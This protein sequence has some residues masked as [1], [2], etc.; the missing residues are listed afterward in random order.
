MCGIVG[1]IDKTKIVGNKSDVIT[2]MSESIRHRGGDASGVFTNDNVAIAH[3]RLAILDLSDLAN[4]PMQNKHSVLAY[5]GEIYNHSEIRD[6][7]LGDVEIT[8]YSDTATLFG[9]LNKYSLDGVLQDI[10]GMYSFS[11]YDQN[12]E[13]V[14]LCVDKFGIKPLY[15]VDTPDWFAWSSEAKAFKELPGFKLELNESRIGEYMQFRY[16]LGKETLYKNVFRVMPGECVNYKIKGGLVS[17]KS[18]FSLLKTGSHDEDLDTLV[19]IGV[20]K[21]LMGD[22]KVGVQL[23]GGIDSSL[24]GLIAQEESV[25][26]I[27]TFSIGLK[28]D[29]WNEFKYSDYVA[30]K[31][32]SKH[33]KIIFTPADF[34]DNLRSVIYHLDEPLVHPNTVPM[35]LLAK[36]ARN[37]VKVLLTGEGADEVFCGYGRYES[38]SEDTN[39]DRLISILNT[40][41]LTTLLKNTP[42]TSCERSEIGKTLRGNIVSRMSTLDIRS[43]LPH[44]LMRQDKAGMMAN[45]ENRVPFLYEPIVQHG[46]NLDSNEKVGERGT[47]TPLK[48]IA[49]KYFPKDFVLREKCGFGLPISTWLKDKKIMKPF[50]NSLLE[51]K[52]MC[53]YFNMDEVNRLINEHLANGKDNSAILFALI[54]LDI[55]NDIFINGNKPKN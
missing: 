44:V 15:Y 27:H 36:E 7:K 42:I 13:E 18:N 53:T 8:S 21:H 12:K 41:E 37:D 1:F 51:S 30:D 2:R 28:D 14:N 47:K 49:L 16:A 23:S 40:D 33:H 48:N 54:S 9:L 3:T 19:R 35:Y 32:K 11:Y 46:Y 5:N 4:Q 29:E 34:V 55:W 6:K 43:Y 17:S 25:D 22:V 31:I 52:I 20:R 10:Q 39:P 26:Q 24:I 50:L 45:V 38:L